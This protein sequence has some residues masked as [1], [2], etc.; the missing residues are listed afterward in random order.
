[1]IAVNLR[2]TPSNKNHA[3]RGGHAHRQ[4]ALG[5]PEMAGKP[6]RSGPKQANLN[7]TH[8]GTS[9]TRLTLGELPLTMRRQTQQAR[10]YRRGL[11]ALVQQAKGEVG[12]TDAHLIDEATTAEV[13]ASVC[14]WLLRTRLDKMSPSDIARCS[15][16]I[17]KSKT[18]R[19]R[20]V[21]RLGLD[22]PQ[23]MPWAIDVTPKPALED[24]A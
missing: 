7:A 8:N 22:A 17:L 5:E 20:A 16:Q 4:H 6:G 15:E 3:L 1:M 19:N 12:V 23:P 11:E 14:R 21:E 13:H 9:I 10:K 18:V 24:N 2:I